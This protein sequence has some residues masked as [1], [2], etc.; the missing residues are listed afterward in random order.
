MPA[1]PVLFSHRSSLEHDTGE[2]PERAERLLAIERLLAREGWL[3]YE[4]LASPP[5]TR[6]ALERVHTVEHIERVAAAA[7]AATARRVALDPDTVLSAGSYEAALHACGGAIE[8]VARLLSGG[9]GQVGVS[10]HRPPGH[11]A[12]ADRAMGFCLFNN[13][14]VAARHAIAAH[15]LERVLVLDWDVHH[16]NG[17]SGIFWHSDEVL[18]VSIHQQPLYPG[19]GAAHELGEGRGRG[20]TVNLPVPP[21]SGDEVFVSLVRDVALPLARA[22]RPELVLVSAG[23]DAHAE[24]PLADCA[25]S[26]AGFATMAALVRGLGDEL[27]VPIGCVLEGGYEPQALARCMALTMRAA[28]LRRAARRFRTARRFRARTAGPSPPARRA[29]ALAPCGALAAA[30]LAALDERTQ[31]RARGGRDP[32]DHDRAGLRAHRHGLCADLRG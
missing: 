21:G 17:T 13:V 4:R 27:A 26:D 25:V 29:G 18:F 22:Y 2:H 6:E 8:L 20:Y 5:A 1:A 7:A 28:R 15:G 14:A 30:K 19:S 32:P 9:A 10:I 16:G 31:L 11:H 24:D 12:L 3:G 23:Y